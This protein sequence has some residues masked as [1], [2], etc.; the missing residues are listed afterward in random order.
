[1]KTILVLSG[2]PGSW[3]SFFAKA[4]VDKHPGQW[5]RV[6]KDSIRELLDNSRYSK[7]NEKIVL[8]TRDFIVETSLENWFSVIID[9]TNLEIRNEE[10][11][12]ELATK[13][14]AKVEVK[15]FD[16]PV[17]TCIERDAKREKPVGELVIR[18]IYNKYLKPA[19]PVIEYNPELPD[20]V[21]V[22]IDGTIA[23]NNWR[24]PYDQ[25][26]VLEDKPIRETI[27][28][29]KTLRNMWWIRIVITTG[30]MDNC[31][32]DTLK[33]LEI[34]EVPCNELLMRKT[35]DVR[36]DSIIKREMYEE[37]IKG[38]YN[39]KFV[40]DDRPQVVRQRR[41]L[42]LFVFDC[43]QGDVF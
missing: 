5:K 19:K 28:I 17:Q 25:T 14:N 12:R 15:F 36:K 27:S 20:C 24:S 22:D 16:T 1:M 42:G 13:H 43:N 4:L 30:R 34:N 32:E 21:V 9:D 33:R 23:D 2:L 35:D 7:I 18:D 26:K 29:I 39:V 3:K 38:K 40:F 31:R 10:R 11:M 41:E 6:N 37:N 8:E